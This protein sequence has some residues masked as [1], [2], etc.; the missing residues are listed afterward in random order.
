MHAGPR[1]RSKRTRIHQTLSC[2]VN[3][4]LM[5]DPS[6]RDVGMDAT[7]NTSANMLEQRS[8]SSERCLSCH[9]AA[10][11]VHARHDPRSFNARSRILI[12]AWLKNGRRSWCD[13][14]A[15]LPTLREA[16]RS[17]ATSC[18]SKSAVSLVRSPQTANSSRLSH[19]D[20][21]VTALERAFQLAKS[22]DCSSVADLKT[23]LRS[24]GYATT[25]I[26]GGTINK[27]LSALIEA[28]RKSS[29]S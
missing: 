14:V 2:G 29:Q 17:A 4:V 12:G 1:R 3:P 24:E 13:D 5:H 22:G 8:N 23:R 28:A 26:V 15:T 20:H 11:I 9:I 7:A 6:G 16:N 18:R 21:N 10:L 25:Q 27:Q 19:M